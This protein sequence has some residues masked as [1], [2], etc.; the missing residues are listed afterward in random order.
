MPELGVGTEEDVGE[1]DA[2]GDDGLR[3]RRDRVLL[4]ED[5]RMRLG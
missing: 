5:G 3:L 2:G 1:A 4:H